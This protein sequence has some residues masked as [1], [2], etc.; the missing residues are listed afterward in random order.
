[1]PGMQPGAYYDP[2]QMIQAQMA[3][4]QQMSRRIGRQVMIS[5]AFTFVVVLGIVAAVFLL[6]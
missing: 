6:R 2:N 1:M 3:H 5:V 4:A